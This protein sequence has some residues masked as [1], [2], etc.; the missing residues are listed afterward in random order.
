MFG[1][2]KNKKNRFCFYLPNEKLYLTSVRTYT[3]GKIFGPNFLAQIK[4]NR[5]AALNSVILV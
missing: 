2:P 1:K 5:H 4:G 3:E